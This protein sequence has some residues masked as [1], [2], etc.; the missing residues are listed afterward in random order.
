MP[1]HRSIT[2]L[3]AL[4]IAAMPAVAQFGWDPNC[5]TTNGSVDTNINGNTNHLEW[6]NW[7][8]GANQ[9]PAS[10]ENTGSGEGFS[11]PPGATT[12]CRD[13]ASVGSEVQIFGLGTNQIEIRFRGSVGTSHNCDDP[14]SPWGITADVVF[15]A[16]ACFIINNGAGPATTVNFEYEATSIT[17]TRH[18]AG[19]ED[20]VSVA[21][22]VLDINSGAAGLNPGDLNAG[23]AVPGGQPVIHLDDAGSFTIDPS[24]GPLTVRLGAVLN[25]TIFSPGDGQRPGCAVGVRDS[26]N[27]YVGGRIALGINGAPPPP[28]TG[29]TFSFPTPPPPNYTPNALAIEFGLDLGSDSELADNATGGC[30]ATNPLN[31]FFDPGDMYAMNG[32]VLFAPTNGIRDDFP[33][34]APAPFV[35]EPGDPNLAPVGAFTPIP[36]LP[37]LG[38]GYLDTDASDALDFNLA[39]IIDPLAPLASP[40]HRFS[41]NTSAI[42]G[43]NRLLIS[44]DDDDPVHYAWCSTAPGSPSPVGFGPYGD[45]TS[46]SE[47]FTAELIYFPT[48]VP[49]SPIVGHIGV[50]VPVASESDV[51]PSL[52]PDVDLL[53]EEFD[54][55]IDALDAQWGAGLASNWYISVDSEAH[56]FDPFSGISLDPADI[57]LAAAPAPILAV[58]HTTHL[59][60]QD[61]TDIDAF[62][63]VWL[64]NPN[65][66]AETLA[67]IFSI[68]DDDPITP[69]DESGS[70]D[71]TMLYAS[72]LD[73]TSFPLLAHPFFDD[74]DA[75]TTWS[76]SLVNLP[77]PCPVDLAP[78]FGQLDFSDVIAF[79]VAFANGD[80]A[81]DLVPDGSFDFS[82]VIAFL[83]AFGAGCP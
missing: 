52:A 78:P 64:P 19:G 39:S 22:S 26:S 18:D 68:D 10:P 65:V 38:A 72:F 56:S 53:T 29:Y 42:H 47:L 15:N 28:S 5:S 33:V 83:V 24:A 81:A 2:A 66:G 74:V 54:D 50:Q 58:H 1:R 70:L 63:F 55:D 11:D 60:L 21:M 35:P 4:A 77:G 20:P 31:N 23:V 80:P 69:I 57:Y 27:G 12:P 36:D 51:H 8:E 79:L 41:I 61:G 43:A 71:P 73:G 16:L 13:F 48:T 67:L 7:D 46:K 45:A 17:W 62:E 14:C 25:A 6:N 49:A 59:G 32:P 34:F 82:D 75:L 76:R 37:A 40:I 44:F 30:F 3:L 9:P